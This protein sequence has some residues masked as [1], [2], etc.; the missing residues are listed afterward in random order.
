M[1]SSLTHIYNTVVS[2][3]K[4]VRNAVGTDIANHVSPEKVHDIIMRKLDLVGDTSSEAR[5]KHIGLIDEVLFEASNSYPVLDLAILWP[6][7][8]LN[9]R[10]ISSLKDHG[11]NTIASIAD[12]ARKRSASRRPPPYKS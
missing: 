6:K 3:E 8:S 1:P 12:A 4:R 9:A 11:F 10:E 7:N 2:F 5:L